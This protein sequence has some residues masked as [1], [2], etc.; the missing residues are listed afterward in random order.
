MKI[1]VVV[2]TYNEEE[3]VERIYERLTILFQNKLSDYEYEILF[4]DNKSTDSTRKRLEG[5]CNRDKKVKCIFNVHNFD[6]RRS[7]FYGL[8]QSDGDATFLVNADMQDPPEMLVDFINEWRQGT[9]VVIGIKSGTKEPFLI[10]LMRKFYYKVIKI[11]SESEQI[12]NFNGFGLYDRTFIDILRRLKETDPYLKGIV[13]EFAPSIKKIPYIQQKR[14]RGTGTVN[15]FRMYDFAMCGI[16]STSKL[17]LRMSTLIGFFI[18]AISL[19]V[20]V[21]VLISK[22]LYW[23]QFQLGLAAVSVGVFFLGGVQLYFIGILGEYILSI[24][25]RLADRPLVVEERRIN[26]DENLEKAG[27]DAK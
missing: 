27:D 23:D 25:L 12:S 8:L 21:S 13:A 19:L 1:G 17:I 11:L 9:P 6:F 5:I 14:N 26:F 18:S 2:P 7:S 16:T 20:A 15:F 22:L 3:N 4:I 24:H 10:R